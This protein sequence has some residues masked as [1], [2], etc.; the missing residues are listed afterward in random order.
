MILL[1]VLGS[2]AK[3]GED[4]QEKP[5]RFLIGSTDKSDSAGV[6][7]AHLNPESG[8]VTVDEFIKTAPGPGYLAFSPDMQAVFIATGD[9]HI[10]SYKFS[11]GSLALINSQPS[12][13][14]N[15]CHV[16][17][18]PSGK[19]IFVSNYTDG[20]FSVYRVGE[21]Y[22]LSEAIYK[23]KYEGKGPHER[24]QEMPHAHCAMVAP[25]GR[26]VYVADL[27]TDRVM[28]YRVDKSGENVQPNPDQPCYKVHAGAGPRHMVVH[29]EGKFLYI[30]NELDATLT[31]VTVNQDGV[32]DSLATYQTIPTGQNEPGNT[33]AAIRLHP[34]G[35][36]LYV[37]N[38]GYNAIHG[39]RIESDG[40][41]TPVTIAREE[42]EI[43]R[44][45]N[46]DPSGRFMIVGNLTTH[47]LTVLSIDPATGELAF[48]KRTGSVTSPS[49]IEFF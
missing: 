23:E 32:L 25:D 8:E 24:R 9:N 41:L 22:R 3:R 11:E 19:M 7:T 10:S 34:N 21:D 44:D 2:C 36:F 30:L 35:K 42:I 47:D 38:R 37:S 4:Q 12:H 18:L 31:A 16:S 33:S 1:G 39:Y 43:P 17:V 49:C 13:G 5:V 27:G 20:T 26:H 45:F 6:Y 28:N 48:R 29:P 15:P 14:L 46:I 40:R